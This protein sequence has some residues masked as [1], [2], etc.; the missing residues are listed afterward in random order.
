MKEKQSDRN[1]RRGRRAWDKRRESRKDIQAF[2]HGPARTFGNNS[3][4]GSNI[5]QQIVRAHKRIHLGGKPAVSGASGSKGRASPRSRK[6]DS[7]TPAMP[8]ARIRQGGAICLWGDGT[9][10]LWLAL[11]DPPACLRRR[12]GA[13]SWSSGNLGAWDMHSTWRGLRAPSRDAGRGQ[14][15][16]GPALPV[17]PAETLAARPA[18]V[19]DDQ[20]ILRRAGEFIVASCPG[21]L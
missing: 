16:F 10:F 4:L 13:L 8:A 1:Q 3:G 21:A 7:T 9:L 14:I 11:R 17:C 20:V 2:L 18:L 5:S 12:L 19:A 6:G 15:R